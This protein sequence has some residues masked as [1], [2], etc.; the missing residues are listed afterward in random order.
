MEV[1]NVI[2]YAYPTIMAEKALKA[3]HDAMLEHN[4][5]VALEHARMA[6]VECRLAYTAI[7][8]AKENQH[9]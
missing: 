1:A 5:D 2:D 4:Y 7:L 6:Q 3:L 9:G 8:A